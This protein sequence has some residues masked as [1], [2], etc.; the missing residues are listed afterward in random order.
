MKCQPH[1]PTDPDRRMWDSHENHP[2]MCLLKK[3]G[4]LG[5]RDFI[6]LPWDQKPEH[7]RPTGGAEG[8]LAREAHLPVK[9]RA[10]KPG[11]K[12]LG[13][14]DWMLRHHIHQETQ[15]R[16]PE[17]SRGRGCQVVIQAPWG[18]A[19]RAGGRR[20][21]EAG[22]RDLGGTHQ[23]KPGAGV[24]PEQLKCHHFLKLQPRK[25]SDE[26]ALDQR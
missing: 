2:S 1:T 3:N 23:T 19:S 9:E 11:D 5:K 8:G 24:D 4:K 7:L 18:G 15:P 6:S 21:R 22:C 13:A 25:V 26:W 10:S 14:R 12:P 16:K 17:G 20:R